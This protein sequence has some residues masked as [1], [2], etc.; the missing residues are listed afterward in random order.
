MNFFAEIHLLQNCVMKKRLMVGQT[1]LFFRRLV[2]NFLNPNHLL[3]MFHKVLDQANLPRMRF[4]D[5]CHSAATILL[6][7]GVHPKVVQELLGHSSITMTMDTY[8]HLLPSMQKDAI[9]GM[10]NLF[11]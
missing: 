7:M 6:A 9:H 8:S 1:H 4:H 5:L 11:K 3:T 2:E 10:D